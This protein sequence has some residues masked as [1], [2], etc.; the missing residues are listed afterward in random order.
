MNFYTVN[1]SP[2][3]RKVHAVINQLGTDVQICELDL[4]AGE[5]NTPEFQALNPNGMVPVLEDG[6][7]RLWESNAIMQYLAA[8]GPANS[9]YPADHRIRADIHRWQAW[10][11]GHFNRA[12]GTFAYETVLKPVLKIGVPDQANL[13]AAKKDFY[14]Y[15]NVLEKQL[16]GKNIVIGDEVT[17]ADFSVGSMADFVDAADVPYHSYPN[18]RAWLKRLD[19]ISAWSE[20][21]KLAA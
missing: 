20:T 2:N 6:S 1:G 19:E 16:E 17:L 8:I 9:I 18:I 15:A 21:P 4:L 3:C 5:L 13:D 7:L 12:V 14:Q 10:E 11:Q